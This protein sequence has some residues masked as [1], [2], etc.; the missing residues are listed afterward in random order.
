M[1]LLRNFARAY[2]ANRILYGRRRRRSPWGA[3]VIGHGPRLRRRRRRDGFGMV[4]PFPAYRRT[5][6]RSHVTVSGCC[7]PIPLT[8]AV[9]GALGARRMLRRR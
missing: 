4:G 6:S 2:I 7:L 3:P 8:L 5:T 1:S 9:G